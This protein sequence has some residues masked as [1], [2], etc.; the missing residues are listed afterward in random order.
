MRQDQLEKLIKAIK[1]EDIPAPQ[2]VFRQHQIIEHKPTARAGHVYVEV[3]RMPFAPPWDVYVMSFGWTIAGGYMSDDERKEKYWTVENDVQNDVS[4]QRRA[5]ELFDRI[6]E[7]VREAQE[8]LAQKT[9]EELAQKT[10]DD[11][12]V[13]V[14][15]FLRP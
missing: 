4:A 8:E 11:L 3:V 5:I 15:N 2:F 1:G 10:Q 9:Q 13:D 7:S 6:A 14:E 12:V